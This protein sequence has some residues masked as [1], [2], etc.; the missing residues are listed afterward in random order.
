MMSFL[1]VFIGGGLGSISRFAISLAFNKGTGDFPLA[2]LIANFLACIVLAAG[3][4]YFQKHVDLNPQWKLFLLTGF[5][6][7]FSTFSTFS[8]ESFLLFQQGQTSMALAY[9][10]ASAISCILAIAI[11]LRILSM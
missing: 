11:T 10:L 2:T 9:M 7:G 4:V 8:M 6:G 5:C 1:A 3:F